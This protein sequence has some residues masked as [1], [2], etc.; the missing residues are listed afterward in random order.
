[1]RDR[2]GPATVTGDAERKRRKPQP[3]GRH[4]RSGKARIG[5]ARKPGDLPPTTKPETLVER[6]GSSPCTSSSP[7]WRPVS[8]CS[9]RRLARSRANVVGPGRRDG[10]HAAARGPR[11]RRRPA[12][13]RKDGNASHQCSR[14]E[15]R[16]RARGAR[17]A[18]TGPGEWAVVRRLRG[19]DDQGRDAQVRGQ[20]R[21][22]A[23]YWSF[24]LNYQLLEHRRLRDPDAGRRRRPAS[25][26]A[27]SGCA[28]GADAAADRRDPGARRR[29]GQAFDVRVV[30]Y[31]VTF[32][33]EFNATTTI[34]AGRGRGGERGRPAVHRGRRRRRARDGWT[35]RAWP[36]CARRRTASCARRPSRCAWTAATTPARRARRRAADTAGPATTLGIKNGKVF[37]RKKAPR[38]LRGK[39][40]S[41][42]SGLSGGQAPAPAQGRQEVLVLLG[43]SRA[44]PQDPPVLARR[45]SSRSATAPTGRTCCRSGSGAG[46]TVLEAYGD[47]RRVQPR[48]DQARRASGCA[49]A[50]AGPRLCWCS[51]SPSRLRPGRRACS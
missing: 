38:T 15:R 14:N 1:M 51:R 13:S 46:A 35:R 45:R 32:D 11:R 34:G 16:R 50:A 37:S 5:R 36:A 21:R 41:D 22:R 17:P 4:V 31:G 48:A 19:P 18:A 39:V 30:Q 7:A 10:G 26:R 43:R 12:P 33:S 25:S 29:Q 3:L 49:D 8:S 6:G 27:A 47:R 20:R 9:S 42:P 44:V 2:R 40:A 23:R 28:T 24:W